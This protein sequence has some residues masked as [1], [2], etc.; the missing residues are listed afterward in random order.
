MIKKH[1]NSFYTSTIILLLL[2][3][4]GNAQTVSKEPKDLFIVGSESINFLSEINNSEYIFHINLPESYNTDSSKTYP[5]FYVLDGSRV[6]GTTTHVYNGIWD[7]GFAPEMIIVG[8][9]FSGEKARPNLHR[10]RDLTPTAIGR[11]SSSGGTPLFLKVLSH[12]IIPL[13]DRLYKTDKTNRTLVGTSFAG[14][15]THYTLFTKPSLFNSYII[16]NPT[17]WW[18]DDYPYKLE[19]AFYQNNKSLNAKVIFLNSEFNDMPSATKMFEQIKKHNYDNMILDFRMI[20][21]MGH[22]GGEAE[23]INQGMRFVYKRSAIKLPEEKLREYC[24]TYKD[25]NY[26][27]EIMIKDGELILTREG[28]LHGEKIKAIS[29]SEFAILGRYFDFHF[30]RNEKGEVIGFFSQQDTNPDRSRTAIKIR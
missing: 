22:L 15:F 12:E 9:T 14:L 19:E 7:D 30:N 28:E 13:I 26:V 17:L 1:I 29:K 27:R 6:F 4:I 23:A 3:L 24:G 21:N 20:E 5:V 16:N 18:D 8:I 10:T 2:S 25:G 11:I